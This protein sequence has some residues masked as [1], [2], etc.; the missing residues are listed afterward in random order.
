MHGR[1]QEMKQANVES[2]VREW[3]M[4]KQKA[5]QSAGKPGLQIVRRSALTGVL[6]PDMPAEV[7]KSLRQE[8]TDDLRL[9]FYRSH[10]SPDLIYAFSR[11]G[12]IV[13]EEN[14]HLLTP[15]QHR[16][17]K[18]ALRE[19]RRRAEAD[20]RAIDLCYTLLH[21]SGRSELANRKRFAV[22]ELGVATLEAHEE[23]ISSFAM[24]GVFFNAWL[25]QLAKRLHILPE[26]GERLRE[27]FGADV[28]ELRGLLEDFYDDLPTPSWNPSIEK[29]I[30]KIESA[31]AIPETWLGK[32]PASKEVAEWEM[33]RA[34]EHLQNAIEFCKDVNDDVMESMFFRT[35]FRTR[36]LNDH[37]PERFFQAI[38]A[39]WSRVYER[40][41]NHM[42]RYA[43]SRLQ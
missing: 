40:V 24:E 33:P 5:R 9:V 13:T 35:W 18:E 7:A 41:Q 38:D 19:Y 3:K 36:V 30:A 31:R 43:G 12:R 15:E 17:W 6:A 28:A 4:A 26:D 14:R 34:V 25:S 32:A 21:E 22:S 11:T 37:L 23:G 16:D 8:L 1:L 10:V 39:N 27:K 42:A 20:E 2:K 29:R